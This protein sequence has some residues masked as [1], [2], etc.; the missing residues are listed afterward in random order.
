MRSNLLSRTTVL[1]VVRFL[2]ANYLPILVG[3][4]VYSIF[5]I[6]TFH[7]SY[8]DEFD[9]ISGGWYILHGLVIYKDF[10]THHGPIAYF[11]AALVEV[12]SGNSFVR[13]R[14]VYSIFLFAF[15]IWTYWYV[16]RSVGK[17]DTV[18][19]IPM[20]FVIAITSVY[21]WGQ[22]LLA[23]TISGYFL[24][25]VFALIILK[26]FYKKIFTIGDLVVVSVLSFLTLLSSLTYTYVLAF[27][28][29]YSLYL[30]VRDNGIALRDYRNIGKALLVFA[31]PY[32]LFGLYLLL[33]GS[34]SYYLYDGI[35]FNQKYYIYN[36]PRPPGST[37]INPVRFAVVIFNNFLMEWTA[38][39]IQVKDFNFNFPINITL[40]IAD[41]FMMVYLLF[42]R[43][44]LLSFFVLMILIFANAR[45]NPLISKETD[46]Q[47]AVYIIF[48]LFA[49]VFM[50]FELFNTLKEHISTEKKAVYS[51]FLLLLSAY[52]LFSSFY[53]MRSFFGKAYGKYM[54]TAP[55][56]Y[57]RPQLAP[58]V[59]D[60]VQP[61]EYT[62]IGP[63]QFEELFYT[64]PPI[65]SRYQIFNPGEGSSQR[66]QSGLIQD[67]EENKP[68][69]VWFDKRFYI[70]GRDPEEYGQQFIRYLN[71]HYE[72]LY[73]HYQNGGTH[74]V[75]NY[76][77][78]DWVD[79][80]GKLYIRKENFDEIVGR[81]LS[82]GYIKLA[83]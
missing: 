42:N 60:I 40:A 25:P 44:Y 23:D 46:Y 74:Y 47:S 11:L 78:A 3:I 18:F 12:F 4:A 8:P 27:V 56:I 54:G 41:L 39:L 65:A 5:F 81:M 16:R 17:K 57:D 64:K 7:E 52:S 79:I 36:Y 45:S 21:F 66:I 80:E 26:V 24:L 67:F 1:R 50:I 13:F 73:E 71:E 69:V 58:F 83:E 34:L 61:G 2:R 9:N 75:S 82:K 63:F 10:F 33:T 55:R 14:I 48:S 62:W 31:T 76:P 77:F 20:L 19:W 70:L 68:K 49:A 51:L 43:K 59:N 22:M 72:T 30:Y 38:L 37:T 32:V 6:N 15:T 53:L 29:A 35:T 28:Y